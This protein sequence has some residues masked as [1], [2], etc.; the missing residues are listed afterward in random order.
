MKYFV[1][2]SGCPPGTAR[3]QTRARELAAGAARAVHDQHGV[4]PPLR[5]LLGVPSVR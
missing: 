2:S 3:R 5:V 1:T 4:G